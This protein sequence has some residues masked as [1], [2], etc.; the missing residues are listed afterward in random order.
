MKFKNYYYLDKTIEPFSY[1]DLGDDHKIYGTDKGITFNK[2]AHFNDKF[3]SGSNPDNNPVTD[4]F[5]INY[6]GNYFGT[7]LDALVLEKTDGNGAYPDGGIVFANTNK[8]NTKTAALVI[9]GTGNIGIN[10]SNPSEKL[11][12]NGN[13]KSTGTITADKF[14]DINNNP[15]GSLPEGAIIMWHG[16]IPPFGWGICDG[17]LDTPDL[18]GRFIVGYDER[19]NNLGNK[20]GNKEIQL[21]EANLP[22]HR[23]SGTTNSGGNHYHSQILTNYGYPIQ[24][25]DLNNSGGPAQYSFARG[26]N[27]NGSLKTN[28]AGSHTHSFNTSYT[29][30]NAKI[31]ITPPYYTLAFIMKLNSKYVNRTIVVLNAEENEYTVNGIK[32]ISF[33]FLQNS[34]IIFYKDANAD[35]LLVGGGGGGGHHKSEDW[36]NAGGGGGGGG[37]FLTKNTSFDGNKTYDI[38]IGSGGSGGS[39]S[40]GSNGGP[41]YIKQSNNIYN[42]LQIN[43]GGGGGRTGN[44]NAGYGNGNTAPSNYGGGGSGGGAGGGW[45]G[46]RSGGSG[47]N[48]GGNGRSGSQYNGGGGG[49]AGGIANSEH[50]GQGKSNNYWNGTNI[51]YAGGGGGGGGNRVDCCGGSRSG[52]QGYDGGGGGFNRNNNGDNNTNGTNGL[53]GGG[54]GGGRWKPDTGDG[55][56]SRN[57]STGG[58]GVCIIRFKS[59][60]ITV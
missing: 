37:G 31:D 36:R 41:T 53:G 48:G 55:S 28:S 57:G 29:G 18:R 60:E 51:K 10:T 17:T 19:Q 58:K 34:S 21:E 12:V 1:L 42:S 24:N 7:Y 54:G 27:D 43:G 35:I 49:G 47:R 40:N 13:I 14:Q 33:K 2:N 38:F 8:D 20:G 44:S 46:S 32:Y 23:H 16:T 59:D 39:N 11:D 45:G 6:E 3:T 56:T 5:R 52:G 4:S 50:G 22:S 9:R 26:G 30:S 25:D 15:I